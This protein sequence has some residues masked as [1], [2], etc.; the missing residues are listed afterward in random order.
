[1]RLRKFFNNE[2]FPIYGTIHNSKALSYTKSNRWFLHGL[3]SYLILFSL[4]QQTPLHAAAKNHH[5]YTVQH[6][7]GKGA[8]VNIKDNNGVSMHVIYTNFVIC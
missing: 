5:D 8:D 2:N 3:L 4:Y 7:I 1:M 6:L